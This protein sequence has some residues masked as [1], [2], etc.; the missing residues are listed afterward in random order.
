MAGTSILVWHSRPRLWPIM[1]GFQTQAF[2]SVFY[3]M[4]LSFA[5]ETSTLRVSPV[6]TPITRSPDHPIFFAFLRVSVVK[7]DF[8]FI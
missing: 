3:G 2:L 1:L 8:E 6:D 5:F 4:N 7:I